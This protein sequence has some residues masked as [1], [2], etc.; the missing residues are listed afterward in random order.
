V[1][2]VG[3]GQQSDVTLEA[4]AG[5]YEIFTSKEMLEKKKVSLVATR[6]R[7]HALAWWRQT[8]S[9]RER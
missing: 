6:L 8:K 3:A 5:E 1:S 7:G 9:G 4:D 2:C